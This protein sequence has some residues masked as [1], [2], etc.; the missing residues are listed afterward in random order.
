MMAALS[1]YLENALLGLLFN[2][3]AFS[4]PDTYVALY[5]DDPTDADV[6]TE[7]TGGSYARERVYDNGGGAPDWTVAAADGIGYKVENDDDI[8]FT[9]ATAAWGTVTHFGI[10]D[11]A[12]G[13]NLLFHGVLGDSKTVGIG[14]VFKIT[15]GLLAMRLE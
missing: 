9:T 10:R 2:D 3:D 13:G 8:T 4:A 1:N 7:V 5:T 12:S 6:G 15:A 14:D 11:A